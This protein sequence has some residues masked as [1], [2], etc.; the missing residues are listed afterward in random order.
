[1]SRLFSNSKPQ[2]PML[3]ASLSDSNPD[4]TICTIRNAI[5]DG[6]DGFL[7]HLQKLAQ[8]H[9]NPEA[10]RRI[11]SYTG[12]KPIYA[13][14][15]R[16]RQKSDEQL[17]EEQIMA[18]KAGA[19]MIDMIGDTFDRS[20]LELTRNPAAI[21]KQQQVIAQVHELGGEVLI[22]SHTH[23]YMTT[24]EVLEHTK[25]LEARGADFIKIAMSVNS[26]E[27]MIESIKTTSIVSRELNV[28]F[29]HICMGSHGKLHRAIGPLVGSC[30]A[31]CVQKYTPNGHKDKVL[32]RAEKQV[33]D[34]IDGR[35]IRTV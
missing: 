19:N 4:D 2:Y 13:M 30:F 31:L 33:L 3:L 10:L 32:L 11:F 8:E 16:G 35:L 9:I 29:L 22:S 18:V 27:E 25:E 21:E 12:G 5:L 23:V 20:P 26:E 34:N 24:E 6:A 14:N 1:M 28:P 15:Y 17:I 7:M